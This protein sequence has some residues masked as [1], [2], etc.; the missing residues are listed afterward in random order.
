M[1]FASKR[2][3]SAPT[4][5]DIL[6]PRE[7]AEILRLLALPLGAEHVPHSL[8]GHR[9]AVQ[10]CQPAKRATSPSP[11]RKPWEGGPIN[12]FKT[13]PVRGDIWPHLNGNPKGTLRCRP[14]GAGGLF[15]PPFYPWL[16]PWATRCRPLRGLPVAVGINVGTPGV[17][18]EDEDTDK[19]QPLGRVAV[20]QSRKSRVRGHS[21][22]VRGP[23][24]LR[25]RDSAT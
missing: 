17:P 10:G 1:T 9:V 15:F 25:V 11:R 24:A 23:A 20:S 7:K 2:P 22:S 18:A 13:S 4:S 21:L 6:S 16:P 19:N 3:S 5:R 12:R 8:L 14:S